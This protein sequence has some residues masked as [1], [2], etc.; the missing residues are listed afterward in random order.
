MMVTT[1]RGHRGPRA[2]RAHHQ[3]QDARTAHLRWALLAGS[4]RGAERL[5]ATRWLRGRRDRRHAGRVHAELLA[6]AAA[7]TCPAGR[8]DGAAGAHGLGLRT[9]QV[10]D[11]SV[12]IVTSPDGSPLS[13]IKLA[14]T[15]AAA[16]ELLA[17]REVL[18]ILRADSALGQWRALLP[19]VLGVERGREDAPLVVVETLLPGTTLESR[20]STH[21]GPLRSILS[22]VIEAMG[23]LYEHTGRVETIDAAHVRSWIDAPLEQLQRLCRMLSPTSVDVVALLERELHD[24]LIGRRAR[25]S[26]THGDFTP[27]NVL[28]D[29]DLRRVTGVVDWAGGRPGQLTSVDQHT[30]L[31]T[32]EATRRG[33][34]IGEVVAGRLTDDG[35]RDDR[36]AVTDLH[37]GARDIDVLDDRAL[38]LLSWLRHIEEIWR[39]SVRHRTHRIWWALNVEPVLWTIATRPPK[40][41]GG[42][43][44]GRVGTPQP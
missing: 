17:Q 26:W 10:C 34:S 36:L 33:R 14:R 1:L 2:E 4:A 27:G 22:P 8:A 29:E 31:L 25:V 19:E 9:L 7:L 18:D 20:L 23:T 37:Q 41:S 38:T 42:S 39:K 44:R 16:G 35:P 15:D 24:A 3:F 6:A 32:A 12:A 40:H 30:M 5:G 28:L 13:V 11:P 21:P 43:C